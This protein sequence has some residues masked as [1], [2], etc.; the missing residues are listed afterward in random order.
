[1]MPEDEAMSK[2]EDDGPTVSPLTT[3]VA[4]QRRHAL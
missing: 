4:P 1:M 2:T 3:T